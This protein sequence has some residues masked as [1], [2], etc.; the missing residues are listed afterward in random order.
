M[1]RMRPPGCLLLLLSWNLQAQ[2]FKTY[3]EAVSAGYYFH[4][5][6]DWV[7]VRPPAED[8]SSLLFE[9]LERWLE[10]GKPVD[11]VELESFL[12][13]LPESAWAA[14]LH[15]SLGHHY[16]DHGRYSMAL[17][18]WEMAYELTRDD[19]GRSRQGIRRVH[20]GLL[21]AVVGEPRAGRDAGAALRRER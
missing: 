17:R 21:D 7:G 12:E 8:E 1:N 5:P 3:T 20:P 2:P 15:A 6:L 18:H 9:A 14:S 13:E 11:P 19:P 10:L 16:L 4:R